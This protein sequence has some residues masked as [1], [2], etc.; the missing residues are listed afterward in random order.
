MT[1]LGGRGI[2]GHHFQQTGHDRGISTCG[3]WNLIFDFI[4][5]VDLPTRLWSLSVG[6]HAYRYKKLPLYDQRA[7]TCFCNSRTFLKNVTLATAERLFE[8]FT[9]VFIGGYSPLSQHFTVLT[10]QDLE[11][12]IDVL[13]KL[14][15]LL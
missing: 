4:V 3:R 14:K 5:S 10:G 15:V 12:F 9:S 13:G 7:N 8:L 2:C 11:H 6:H 1:L